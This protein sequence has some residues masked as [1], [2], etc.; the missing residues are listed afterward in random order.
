MYCL[1][2]LGRN[3]SL[4]EPDAYG[5]SWARDRIQ[6]IAMTYTTAAAT[7]DPLTHCTVL[8]GGQTHASA[9]TPAATEITPDP[10]LAAPQWEL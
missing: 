1:K 2:L 7:S 8:C 6:A 10:Y 3:F 5:S 4:A 9:V